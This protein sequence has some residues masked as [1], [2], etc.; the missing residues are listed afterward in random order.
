MKNVLLMTLL[1]TGLVACDDNNNDT[2]PNVQA[3]IS[4][5]ESVAKEG[6]WVVTYFWDTDK[7]ETSDFTGYVFVFA[8][9]GTITATKGATTATGQWSVTSDDNSKDDDNDKLGDVDFN[10][11]FSTPASFEEL[12]EDWEIL[13]LT[14][15]KIELKHV[16]G[17]NGGTDFL[18]FEKD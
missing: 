14:A 6:Q 17:G 10:I 12:S 18:T 1:V 13:S 7:D 15:A 4:E 9:N 5:V 2:N 16:S 8:S 11:T 3:Q